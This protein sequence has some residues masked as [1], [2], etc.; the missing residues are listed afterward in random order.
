MRRSRQVT[1]TPANC[2]IPSSF[3]LPV[4]AD[5]MDQTS[6]FHCTASEFLTHRGCEHNQNGGGC[7][8]LSVSGS[9]GLGGQGLWNTKKI[10]AMASFVLQMLLSVSLCWVLSLIQDFQIE[11]SAVCRPFLSSSGTSGKE[12]SWAVFSL[13]SKQCGLEIILGCSVPEG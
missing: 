4:E 8:W 13:H 6:H 5:V 1:P 10:S 11:H 3:S 7:T 9:D 2:A 12:V